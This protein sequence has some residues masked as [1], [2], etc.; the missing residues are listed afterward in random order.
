MFS[1]EQVQSTV[2][3][4][5]D[6]RYV[7][8]FAVSCIVILM[9][10]YF[11]SCFLSFRH[12]LC[13]FSGRFW[14]CSCELGK[15][16][17]IELCIHQMLLSPSL[18]CL[19]VKLVVFTFIL[20]GLIGVVQKSGGGIGLGRLLYRFTSTR[21]RW[22]IVYNYWHY[23]YPSS[24]GLTWTCIWP[25]LHVYILVAYSVTSYPWVSVYVVILPCNLCS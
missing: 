7:I 16:L 3:C 19:I 13:W 23:N 18:V 21:R 14:P 11:L 10:C 24:F 15:T 9:M 25:D 2:S 1:R 12:L 17:S 5:P 4:P 6:I 22:L 20:G 8:V